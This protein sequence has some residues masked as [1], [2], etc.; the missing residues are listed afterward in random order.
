MWTNPYA[1]RRPDHRYYSHV[2]FFQM[3]NGRWLIFDLVTGRRMEFRIMFLEEPGVESLMG[4]GSLDVREFLRGWQQQ[5]GRTQASSAAAP[6]GS[7]LQSQ[8]GGWGRD[9]DIG[10]R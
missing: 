8:G 3:M 2:G 4:L 5:G 9:L 7:Q 10:G 1:V 6:G